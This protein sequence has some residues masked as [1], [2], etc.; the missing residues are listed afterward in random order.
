[1]P[2]TPSGARRRP[3][4]SSLEKRRL[5]HSHQSL[6]LASDDPANCTIDDSRPSSGHTGV[7][8]DGKRADDCPDDSDDGVEESLGS[9]VNTPTPFD[10][11]FMQ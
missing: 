6:V 3:R 10:Q 5:A 9:I 4:S 1:M 8:S 11:P 7:S 2:A